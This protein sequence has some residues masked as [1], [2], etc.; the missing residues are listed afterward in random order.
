MYNY[1]SIYQYTTQLYQ[2]RCSHGVN[3]VN[4]ACIRVVRIMDLASIYHRLALRR[5]PMG[6]SRLTVCEQ[7]GWC[8]TCMRAAA[9]L[10]ARILNRYEWPIDWNR[11]LTLERPGSPASTVNAVNNTARKMNQWRRTS[12]GQGLLRKSRRCL[13]QCTFVPQR[14]TILSWWRV[15]KIGNRKLLHSPTLIIHWWLNG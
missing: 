2:Y 11:S 4:V 13:H 10:Y 6:P 8:L 5:W 1:T 7:W 9:D 3:R 14:P 15:L 12:L